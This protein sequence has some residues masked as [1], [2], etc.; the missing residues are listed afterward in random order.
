MRLSRWIYLPFTLLL[1]AACSSNSGGPSAPCLFCPTPTLASPVVGVTHA[2][3]AQ[4]AVTAFLE[5]L[6][7][8]DLTAMYGMLSSASQA[9]VPQDAFLTKYNDALNTM[10]AA[11][12]D[13][14]VISL[15]G[16]NPTAAQV[17]GK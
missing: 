1:L 13:Y 8:N 2:P 10:G 15:R 6:K 12:L 3:D 9:A 11:T 7:S 4:A 17:V 14:Q 5:A 16:M